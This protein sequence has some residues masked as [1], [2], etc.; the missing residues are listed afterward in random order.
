MRAFTIFLAAAAIAIAACG[1]ATAAGPAAAGPTASAA[2]NCSI[3]GD[4][5]KLGASYVT[6]LSVGGISCATGKSLVRNYHACRRSHGGARG[7]CGAV[8]GYRCTE[9]RP[10]S[11]RFEFDAHAT[12][13][14]GSRFFSQNYTQ[15]T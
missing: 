13:T 10:I 8:S 5:R 4:T 9:R 15:L 14:R 2:K 3:G 6:K 12:C 11:S 1:S 7:H